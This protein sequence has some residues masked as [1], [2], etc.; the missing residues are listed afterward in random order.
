MP[1]E[2]VFDDISENNIV[3]TKRSEDPKKGANKERDGNKATKK[4]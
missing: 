3:N 4:Y 2:V 1:K